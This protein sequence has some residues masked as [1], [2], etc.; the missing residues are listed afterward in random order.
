MS[1]LKELQGKLIQY[2]IDH[3]E[4]IKKLVITEVPFSNDDQYGTCLEIEV[5]FKT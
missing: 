4:L 5:E 3:P 1:K 2:A